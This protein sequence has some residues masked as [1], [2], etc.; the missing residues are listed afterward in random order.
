MTFWRL[1]VP[2]RTSIP[3]TI[4]AASRGSVKVYRRDLVLRRP[5]EPHPGPDFVRQRS[6]WRTAGV[7]SHASCTPAR[8]RSHKYDWAALYILNVK[9]IQRDKSV[10]DSR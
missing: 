3:I 6:Q 2:T 1:A 4:I 7:P 5:D 10:C 8:V 9:T